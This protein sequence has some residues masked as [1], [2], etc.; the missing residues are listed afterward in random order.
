MR[1]LLCSHVSRPLLYICACYRHVNRFSVFCRVLHGSIPDGIVIH[2]RYRNLD[3]LSLRLCFLENRYR[4]QMDLSWD[5]L[6][7]AHQT[8][9]RWRDK[10]QVWRSSKEINLPEVKK[11]VHEII[12]DLADDLDTPRALQK[13]RKIEKSQDLS[14]GTKFEVFKELDVLFGLDLLNSSSSRAEIPSHLNELLLRRAKA[15]S[16][17]DFAESDRLRD[18]LAEND[19]LV[20]DGKDGQSW[21]WL[22]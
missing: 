11:I 13:L 5:S 3:P 6:K 16:M 18:L 22:I 9:K 20:K 21:D 2:F 1:V 7:A 12:T 19:I 8:I 14:Y 4:S 15:R 17:G 10:I